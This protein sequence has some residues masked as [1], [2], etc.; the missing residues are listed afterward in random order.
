MVVTQ[1]SKRDWVD[2]QHGANTFSSESEK[3]TSNPLKPR[4]SR[5]DS[6]SWMQQPVRTDESWVPM[7]L[8]THGAVDSGQA[9]VVRPPSPSKRVQAGNQEQARSSSR[10]RQSQDG[11]SHHRRATAES[12][13]RAKP[14]QVYPG[15]IGNSGP[16]GNATRSN[17]QSRIRA[18][19]RERAPCDSSAR[20]PKTRGRSS[21]RTRTVPEKRERSISQ[22]R[23]VGGTSQSSHNRTDPSKN[24]GRSRPPVTARNAEA[25][26]TRAQSPSNP[27]DG[28][29]RTARSRSASLTRVTNTPQAPPSPAVRSVK[30]ASHTISKPPAATNGANVP[31]GRSKTASTHSR[32]SRSFSDEADHD[33]NIGRDISFR[34]GNGS[35]ASSKKGIMGKVLASSEQEGGKKTESGGMGKHIRPRVLLAATVYHNT[36][37]GL[38]IT[39][40]NTN[41]KGVARDPKLANKFLKAFSFPSEQEARESA[42]SNAPP[43]M[44]PFSECNE[45]FLCKCTFTVFKRACHCRNCGVCVCKECSVQW[46]SKMIPETYNLKNEA[47]VKVCRSCNTLS[48]AFRRALVQGD[49]E[50]ALALYGTGNVNLRTP[51]PV[52]GKKDE[53][54]W[55]VHCAVEGGNI[56][57]LRWLVDVRFCPITTIPSGTRK[58]RRG[59]RESLITTSAGRH[60]LSIAIETLKVDIM[61]Y[62]VVDRGVSIYESTELEPSLRALEATLIAL[63]R[64]SELHHLGDEEPEPRWDNGSFDDISVPSTIGVESEK[65]GYDDNTTIGSRTKNSDCCIICFERKIDCVATPC[66]HQICCLECS[67]NLS[68]CPVCNHKGDFIRIFRP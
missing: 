12:S 20:P 67:S 27:R 60:V 43:K 65:V 3:S 21:S 52:S 59:T 58:P 29:S 39:T 9:C 61:H 57:I 50:S 49:Y 36:A 1:T 56:N 32:S 24:R 47:I 2:F 63:P 19:S 51:F 53:I 14:K 10:S 25:P 40:I 7:E 66:G 64:P 41:Q 6:S 37:T 17:S 62:L 68:S 31:N 4:K 38:W 13:L 35:V 48:R 23:S 22:P 34:N 5:Q 18:A 8:P 55:P 30:S 42:I 44:V 15:G 11:S 33:A 46:P 45:C 16:G 28:R 26:P 54:M